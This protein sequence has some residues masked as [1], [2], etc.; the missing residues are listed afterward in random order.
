MCGSVAVWRV[1]GPSGPIQERAPELT[2][3]AAQRGRRRKEYGADPTVPAP[4]Q[5]VARRPRESA[6]HARGTSHLD[7]VPQLFSM[8][9]VKA[10]PRAAR[11]GGRG[12]RVL[13][14]PPRDPGSPNRNK[15]G[16]RGSGYLFRNKRVEGRTARPLVNTTDLPQCKAG[17]LQQEW[18]QGGT[19]KRGVSTNADLKED[20]PAG[21]GTP[22]KPGE[23]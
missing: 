5:D 8:N 11:A 9:A 17:N 7:S 10:P 23:W 16:G 15:W 13:R 2:A 6:S 21:E 22:Q 18:R 4:D 1:I 19:W 14:S 20:S 12:H 3:T